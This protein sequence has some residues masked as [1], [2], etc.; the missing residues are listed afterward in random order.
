MMRLPERFAA[1][2]KIILR[3][4][5]NNPTSPS[6]YL[7][8]KEQIAEFLKNPYSNEKGLR[9]SV[10]YIYGASSH[11]RR[12]IQYFAG[13]SDLAYVV[14][15]S[16]VDVSS[17]NAKTFKNNYIKTLNFLTS[18][19]IKNQFSKILTVCLRE[20]TFFGTMWV[21]ADNITIQQLPA[22]FCTVSTIE[23]GVLNVSFNFS[24]FDTNSAQLD[25][26]PPEFSSKYKQYQSN[27]TGLKWQELDSPTS[28]AI[29][30]NN[31]I[32]SYSIPPFAGILRNIY[33]I[34]DYK[35]LKLT[36]T[37]LENYAI[38]VMTLGMNDDGE[39]SMDLD[40]AKEFWRNLDKVL[41]EEIGSIL[42]PMPIEKISFERSGVADANHIAEAEDMLFSAA[43]VSS[44]LFNNPKA[45]ANALALSIKADQSVTYGIVKSIEGMVN[46]LLLSRPFGKSFKAT[47]LDVS[48]YNR[49]EAGEAYLKACQYGMPMVSYYCASQGLMQAEMDAMNYLED[50]VLG[51][52]SRFKPLQ[53]SSTRSAEDDRGRPEAE[54]SELTEAGE[55]SRE[56][57]EG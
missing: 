51:I 13:L 11:F 24:Y 8:T 31:D 19:D 28:F 38:L 14:S 55:N 10:I 52:K 32:L 43:G 7:Y 30:C 20:D 21:T 25:F 2:N 46:R 5:N 18:M 47:F 39:W 36:K 17:V 3:D 34:E 56:R 4:L 6:F 49:K 12:L 53:S 54:D 16:K 45:S 33:D 48:P 35:Q 9:D 1:L 42:T 57:G 37:E 22:D 15:P 44:L 26:Y 29:K 50:D 40:K 27:R 23:G 41:P